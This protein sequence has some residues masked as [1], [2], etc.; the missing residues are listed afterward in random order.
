VRDEVLYRIA[1][2]GYLARER[3]QIEKLAHIEQIKIPR[4][5]DFLALS[6]LR[7]ESALKL[8]EIKPATLGQAS[9]ISGVG[10]ADIGIL[11]VRIEAGRGA[12][13]R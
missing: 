11:M 10:P 1:Y 4:D 9:R 12:A 7:R 5:M 8:A 6:G 13:K 2:H 3:R